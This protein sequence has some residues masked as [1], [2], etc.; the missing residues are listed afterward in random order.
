[1]VQFAGL[2]VYH[3]WMI[4]YQSNT[5][6]NADDPCGQTICMKGVP[7]GPLQ[8]YPRI[9]GID[10]ESRANISYYPRP[11]MVNAFCTLER[12]EGSKQS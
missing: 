3:F 5:W 4:E 6:V 11:L 8:R 9:Q 10:V 7:M 1:M 12:L 2:S